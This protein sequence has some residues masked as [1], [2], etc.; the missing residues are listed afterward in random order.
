VQRPGR[1]NRCKFFHTRNSIEEALRAFRF[2]PFSNWAV[3]WSV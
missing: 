3:L 2:Q 1:K